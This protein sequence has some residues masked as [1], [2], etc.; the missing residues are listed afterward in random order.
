MTGV[1]LLLWAR[2]YDRAH[3]NGTIAVGVAILT[4]VV[5]SSYLRCTRS[6][7]EVKLNGWPSPLATIIVISIMLPFHGDNTALIFGS[8]LNAIQFCALLRRLN[9]ERDSKRE[10]Y[11]QCGWGRALV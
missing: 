8:L 6:Q 7:L 3:T 4:R 11:F 10:V 5:A 9:S 2:Y 1:S